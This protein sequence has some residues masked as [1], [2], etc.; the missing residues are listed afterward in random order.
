MQWLHIRDFD[1]NDEK[2]EQHFPEFSGMRADM[3][4]ESLQ[5][6]T[7]LV[8]ENAS[9]L[10]LFDADYTF[11][12]ESMAKYYGIPNVIGP[13][14]RRVDGVRQYS[15]GGILGFASTLSKQ[16]ALHAPV[17]F[18]EAIGSPRWCSV[19]NFPSRRKMSLPFQRIFPKDLRNVN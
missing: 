15:R 2:S 1:R 5:F 13:Q 3:Y 11:L 19:K 4:E 9:V 18:C 14:W 16:S 8:Q 12:N 6:L 10:D 17:Q 7:H